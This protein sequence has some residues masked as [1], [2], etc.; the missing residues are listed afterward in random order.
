MIEPPPG[1]IMPGKVNPV[2]A[3]MMM[4]VSSQVIGNDTA[5]T[6]GGANGNFELNVMLPVIAKNVLDMERMADA[7]EGIKTMDH[8]PDWIIIRRA[9]GAAWFMSFASNNGAVGAG[10]DTFGFPDGSFY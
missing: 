8:R 3:E 6:W 2:I 4:Q 1:S 9:Q 7:N 5:I 10:C